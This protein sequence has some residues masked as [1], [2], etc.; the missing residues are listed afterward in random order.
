MW[1]GTLLFKK[2]VDYFVDIGYEKGY[3]EGTE[4]MNNNIKS[5]LKEFIELINDDET[6]SNSKL[7]ILEYTIRGLIRNMDKKKR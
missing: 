3:F 2:N 7:T 4:D 6:C 5:L 1:G